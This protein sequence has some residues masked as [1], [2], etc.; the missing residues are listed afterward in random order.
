MPRDLRKN[1]PDYRR[2]VALRYRGEHDLAPQVTAAGQRIEADLLVRLEKNAIAIEGA[3]LFE[4]QTM[5]ESVCS[6]SI[7]NWNVTANIGN[8]T[9][10][11]IQSCQIDQC[12]SE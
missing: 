12:Y 11:I 5:A 7:S 8:N 2:A 3:S 10:Q 6:L 1:K 4:A 9:F